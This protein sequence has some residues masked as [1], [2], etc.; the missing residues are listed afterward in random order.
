MET[1]SNGEATKRKRWK[2]TRLCF[3]LYPPEDIERVEKQRILSECRTYI[4]RLLSKGPIGADELWCELIQYQDF[5][6]KALSTLML[7][8]VVKKGWSASTCQ[9]VYYLSK[10]RRQKSI[11][12]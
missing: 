9:S 12:P 4:V 3:F 5:Y 11:N 7:R 10:W 6:E 2:Q 8:K 1:P